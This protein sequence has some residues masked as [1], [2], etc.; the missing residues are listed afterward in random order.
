MGYW[1]DVNPGQAFQPSAQLENDVRHLVNQG[2]LSGVRASVGGVQIENICINA[3]NPLNVT[4]ADGD[5]VSIPEG[6]LSEGAFPVATL[7]E[8]ELWQNN[9]GIAQGEIGPHQYGSVLVMGAAIVPIVSETGTDTFEFVVPVG[10]GGSFKKSKRGIARYIRPV[11]TGYALIFVGISSG[12]VYDQGVGVQITGGTYGIAPVI[13][14][15]IE[16]GANITITGGTDGVP[17]TIS[18]SGGGGG[19][20]FYVPQYSQ[21]YVS[22]NLT[23]DDHGRATTFIIPVK[24]GTIYISDDG[25]GAVA[26]Y[27][28]ITGTTHHEI[29][30]GE[31]EDYEAPA[32]GWL[33]VSVYDDGTHGGACLRVSSYTGT[34]P[35]YKYGGHASGNVGYPDYIALAGGTASNSLGTITDEDYSGGAVPGPSSMPS[36]PKLGITYFLPVSAG[37]AIKYYASVAAL[38]R[39]APVSGGYHFYYD[40]SNELE[41]TPN[42]DGWL[43]ISLLDDGN[44]SSECFRIYIGGEQWSDAVPLYKGGKFGNQGATGITSTISG[45]SASITLTGGSGSVKVKPGNN[46]I[47]ITGSNGVIA[48]SAS[49]VDGI[50]NPDYI[51]LAGGTAS[52]SLGSITDEEYEEGVTVITGSTVPDNPAL[53]ITYLLPV[54]A[55]APIKYYASADC[56]VRYAPYYEDNASHYYHDLSESLEWTPSAGG[57][58]RISILDDGSHS[59]DCIRIYVDGEDYSDALPLYKC[60][61]FNGGAT[62]ISSTASGGTA[63]VVSLTGGSGSVTFMPGNAN[64]SINGSTNGVIKISA[65]GGGGGGGFIPA[66]SNSGH[67]DV[68]PISSS[69]WGD[70]YVANADGWLF[71]CAYFDPAEDRMRYKRYD[72]H[73][74]VNNGSMKVAELK[75][76]SGSAF[77]KIEGS[78]TKYYRAFDDDWSNAPYAEHPYYAYFA[79]QA[80][81]DGPIIYTASVTPVIGDSTYTYDDVEEEFVETQN[82][83][84]D[85]NSAAYAV[86]VGSG[87]TVPVR[88]GAT[89]YFIATADGVA[90]NNRYATPYCFC[91]FYSSNPP[92]SE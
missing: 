16:A 85:T 70:G 82:D 50:G 12:S 71:A 6:A 87:L 81:E 9:W 33:R 21:L 30:I 80:G 20:T 24:S 92:A 14:S 74:V 91:V 41:W 58:L 73:V 38:V 86:G 46:K 18:A 45:T 84:D 8:H 32:D 15:K 47:S 29:D 19:S 11:G 4:I 76:P 28:D 53:G 69:T 36:D 34:I 1:P 61:S 27:T 88:A 57:W 60:G 52:N 3:S 78:S 23:S 13:S 55:N 31:G 43:R 22:G 17:Y 63:A 25:G 79:W 77:F 90:I 68:L 44:H 89:I 26:A 2:G 75:L 10:N 7:T 54:P 67:T 40:L 62:G 49:G 37:S 65:T 56:L 48:I 64:V 83:V 42:C 59:G 51:A 66:W 5:A 39:F 35:L 72:A